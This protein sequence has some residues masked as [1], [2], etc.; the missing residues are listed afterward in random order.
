[1]VARRA[2]S[3]KI[4]YQKS[5]YFSKKFGFLG[6][7][8]MLVRGYHTG[9][10]VITFLSMLNV[11][12]IF[13]LGVKVGIAADP[14]GIKGVQKYLARVK[15]EYDDMKEKDKK[16]FD[17]SRLKNPYPDSHIHV[18]DGRKDVKRVIAGIDIDAGEI[19]MATQLTER[20]KKIDLAIAHHPTGNALA[21]L[22][23]VMEMSTSV[24]ES[25]GLPTH[26]A[27]KV[28][29]DRLQEVG[30][31]VHGINHHR[32]VDIARILGVNFMSTHTITDNL[33]NKFLTDLV[34]KEKPETLGEM[35]DLFMEVPEFQEAKRRGAGPKI[36]AGNRHKK[37]GKWIVEMTGG[38]EPSSQV[39]EEFGRI[40]F[41]TIVSMHL[42]EDALKRVNEQHMNSIITGH[43]SSDSIGMNLFLD[44]LEKKGVE[45]IPCGGLIRVSRVGKKK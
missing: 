11:Q 5:P 14:R 7:D 36:V 22:H 6:F 38:T 21:S 12:N 39:Y 4:F 23:E 28:S 27:E 41:S 1:M 31:G 8:K 33:V 42:R 10:F 45:I 16:Y 29:S 35:V 3:V 19:L 15:K 34:A 13:D 9:D 44:E 26:V 37:V 25:F 43:M 40:G 17:A 30:R 18:D 20:G 2:N 32:G 24:F